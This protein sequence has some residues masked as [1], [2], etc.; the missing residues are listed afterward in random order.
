[1]KI[2]EINKLKKNENLRKKNHNSFVC[3]QQQKKMIVKFERK[4][5][6]SS[7]IR[8]VIQIK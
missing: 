5:I 2:H 1:M 6:I 7:P 4:N 3:Q 8:K